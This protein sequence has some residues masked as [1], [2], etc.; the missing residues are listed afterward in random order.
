MKVSIIV[1]TY[2]RIETIEN[3]INSL[4]NQSY[5]GKYEIIVVD[6]G[7]NDGTREYLENIKDEKVKVLLLNSDEGPGDARNIGFENSKGKYI[8]FTDSDCVVPK[9]WIEKHIKCHKTNKNI[10]IVNG[11]QLPREKNIVEAFKTS[12]YWKRNREKFIIEDENAFRSVSTNNL[13]S[14]RKAFEQTGKFNPELTRAED[15]DHGRRALQE[16]YKILHD[17]GIK[18]LHQRKDSLIEFFRT[19]YQL[20]QSMNELQKKEIR[21]NPRMNSKY[22]LNMWKDFISHVGLVRAW[23]FPIIAALSV[24][25]RKLGQINGGSG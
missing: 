2:N 7:S 5:E 16:G 15:T 21:H 8:L 3:T 4:L 18:V 20:G 12:R 10:D 14:T 25:S 22:I 23:T 19:K 9:D 17:P 1:P 11:I 24:T 6:G 13:S